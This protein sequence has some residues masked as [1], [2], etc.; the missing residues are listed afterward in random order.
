[1][2][3]V[4]AIL[5]ALLLVLA[6]APSARAEGPAWAATLDEA[7]STAAAS[8]RLVMV[9]VFSDTCPVC[10]KLDAEVLRNAEVL[11]LLAEVVP[12]RL[13][14]GKEGKT[15]AKEWR[16]AET[17]TIVFLDETGR[18]VGAIGGFLPARLFAGELRRA[19]SGQKRL[20]EL[21]ER[22]AKDPS[23]LAARA[24][25]ATIYADRGDLESATAAIEGIATADPQNEKGLLF[26][27]WLALGEAY[28]A[29]NR[30]A[31]AIPV[32]RQAAE[33]GKTPTEVGY[34]RISL[35]STA[36]DMKDAAT[37][38]AECQELLKMPDLTKDHRVMVEGLL[39]RARA[40]PAK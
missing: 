24:L 26:K 4:P 28:Q 17:P 21:R 23:D 7:K 29:A 30:P 39:K 8:G 16:V 37:A 15:Q 19:I 1:M 10:K 25:L 13:N 11:P 34:A 5:L 20:P 9:E 36:L 33:S 18:K 32:F 12:V 22:V 2:R 27:A 3:P 35:A 14:Q 38:I 31:E 40:L 6:A